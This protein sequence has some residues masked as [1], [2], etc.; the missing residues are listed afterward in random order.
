MEDDRTQIGII[1]STAAAEVDHVRPEPRQR[2]ADFAAHQIALRNPVA[3]AAHAAEA[4]RI[5][6]IRSSNPA[7]ISQATESTASRAHA[8]ILEHALVLTELKAEAALRVGIGFSAWIA[9]AH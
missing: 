9:V 7:L 2:R 3:A 1:E 5:G 4:S 8:R 6:S